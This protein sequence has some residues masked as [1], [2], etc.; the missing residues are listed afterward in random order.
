M[1]DVL[2]DTSVWIAHF[3]G[4]DCPETDR[5]DSLL[6]QDR[7]ALCG[8]VEME[9]LRGVRPAE[10]NRLASLL[11]SL[12]YVEILREDFVAAGER[13][14]QLREQGITIPATDALIGMVCKRN[15][16]ALLT[17]DSHFEHLREVK[18]AER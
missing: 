7:V 12:H 3:R 2:A 17:L 1:A 18:R 4:K 11:E 14:C 6:Q 9:L 8:V 10:R 13:L 15:R 16:L 5:L